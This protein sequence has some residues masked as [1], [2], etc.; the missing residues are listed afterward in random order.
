MLSRDFKY[1]YFFII[2]IAFIIGGSSVFIVNYFHPGLLTQEVTNINKIEKEVTITDKG[3]ADS[4]EKIYDSVVIIENF[5]G[6][7]LKATGTGFIYKKT[8]DIYY[9]LTNQ[10]V[11]QGGNLVKMI[12]TD[13]SEV[14]LNVIGGDQFADICV[15]SYKSDKDLS[16]ANIGSSVKT[17]VGDTVFAIGAPLDSS[18]YSWSIT[19]G[20]L[21]GK[22]REVAV[23]VNSSTVND[24]IMNVIQTDAAINSGNS[25]GPLCNSNGD[26][27]GM[28]NMKLISSG[29]E[30]MGF[31][32]PIEDVSS[33]ADAIINGEDISR[34]SLGIGMYE[35]SN[36]LYA[37]NIY[38]ISY[39]V[40]ITKIYELSPAY[41]SALQVNDIIIDI[42]NDQVSNIA[43]LRVKLFKH[44]IND[45]VKVKYMRNGEI[46]STEVKL[47]KYT[48]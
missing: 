35:I 9:I 46:Y 26:V 32:I 25:G 41:E 31:A 27:I 13:G 44:K 38:G 12:T 33:Y 30:G 40:G 8:D 18:V 29:V 36:S 19:R 16:V 17:R 24:W 4:V 6:N 15:L 37:Q 11:V 47:F 5:S 1:S 3:I 34:P 23:K 43:E 22:D 21:S 7:Q 10:H 20:V 42:D 14:E 48:G 2:F 45:E 28:T 39:G